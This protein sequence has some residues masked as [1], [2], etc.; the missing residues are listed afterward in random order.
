[1]SV[2]KEPYEEERPT[3]KKI[4]L[5]AMKAL[6]TKKSDEIPLDVLNV[7]LI[8]NEKGEPSGRMIFADILIPSESGLH[9]FRE[10]CGPIPGNIYKRTG[11]LKPEFYWQY[12]P[13]YTIP[14][15]EIIDW[16]IVEVNKNEVVNI[17]TKSA[18]IQIFGP[19]SFTKEGETVRV[20][21]SDITKYLPKMQLGET[22]IV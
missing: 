21:V 15:S 13:V 14:Y 12:E 8:V 6:G 9:A 10:D 11:L 2:G 19:K 18:E 16:K 1:M 4:M 7:G 3:R 5:R 22:P 17:V 20:D